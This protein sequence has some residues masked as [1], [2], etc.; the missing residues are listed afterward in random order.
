MMIKLVYLLNYNQ[1]LYSPRT[2][3]HMDKTNYKIFYFF[4]QL[5]IIPFAHNI[6]IITILLIYLIILNKIKIPKKIKKKWLAL[7]IIII[8]IYVVHMY[9]I[10]QI[11]FKN[12]ILHNKSI[13]TIQPF[14]FLRYFVTCQAYILNKITQLS[15]CI[16]LSFFRLINISLIYIITIDII[17]LTTYYESI[18]YFLIQNIKNNTKLFFYNKTTFIIIMA[19]QFIKIIF[20]EIIKLHI[21]YSIRNTNINTNKI[22]NKQNMTSY[23]YLLINY[24]FRLFYYIRYITYSLYSRSICI[25][26]LFFYINN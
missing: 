1:Y 8:F 24:L 3:L 2:R 9:F 11:K 20:L 21:S 4:L 17:L 22:L 5:S 18:I 25:N 7:S 15:I 6:Y 19:S 23:Y 12:I 26:N 13:I 10:T 14:N 16:S